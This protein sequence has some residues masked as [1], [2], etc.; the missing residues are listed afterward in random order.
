MDLQE[1]G[2]SPASALEALAR[3]TGPRGLGTPASPVPL[4][5]AEQSGGEIRGV[6]RRLLLH[7]GHASIAEAGPYK[8]GLE[9][10][11]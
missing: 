3:G 9:A 11:D 2:N 6:R 7:N 8:N 10:G 1:P 4:S 5:G